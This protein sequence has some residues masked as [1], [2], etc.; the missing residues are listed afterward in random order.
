MVTAARPSRV[1]GND[2]RK[3]KVPPVEEFVPTLPV[4]V[5]IPY[6]EAPEALALTLAALEGQTYPSDLIEVIVVDDGSTVPL[7]LPEGVDLDVT[8]IRQDRRGFGAARARNRGA[9]AASHD[10]LVFLDCD[11][12]PEA[13][14]LAAH[15]RWHHTVSDALTLG[16][17][18]HVE[19]DGLDPG[20]VR[21]RPG[22][23]EDLFSDRPAERPEWIE[24]HMART[25][26][27]TSTADDIFRVVTSGNLGVGKGFFE[28]VGGFDESF[29]QWG[30]EDTEFG[31]RA[32]TWGGLLV[33]ERRAFCWHQGAGAAPSEEESRSLDLQQAKIAH[34]IAH[35]RFRR[36]SPGRTFA[37]PQFVVS[38]ETGDAPIDQVF[39]VIE[40]VLGDRIHDL[41]VRVEDR[42]ADASFELIR[43]HFGPDP[44]VRFGQPDQALD[45]FPTAS[46]HMRV[47]PGADLAANVVYTMRAELGGSVQ[48]TMALGDGSQVSIIRTW[49]LHR[50]RRNGR[51]VEEMGA[52][53]TVKAGS[54]VPVSTRKR[55]RDTLAVLIRW[56]RSRSR[57]TYWTLRRIRAR[58]FGLVRA[59]LRI[60]N[61]RQA[62][63]FLKWLAGAVHTRL[64]VWL[65]S[66]FRPPVEALP[67]ADYPLGAEIVAVG[68][69][70]G[71]VLGASGRVRRVLDERHTDL[72][73]AERA[74]PV[75]TGLDPDVP[76]VL[77]SEQPVQLSVPAFDPRSTNPIGWRRDADAGI[78]GLGPVE[79]L[80]PGTVADGAVQLGDRDRLL[81]VRYAVDVAAFH[82]D[83]VSRAGTLAALAATGV[84]VWL[85]DADPDLEAALG[86]GL[87]RLMRDE[88]ILHADPGERELLSV[89]MRREAHRTHSLAARACRIIS[90]APALDPPRVPD[91]TVLAVAA[92][93][94]L[95]SGL[96]DSVA[97]QTYPRLD[98]VLVL[99]G[100]GFGSDVQ[101][102]AEAFKHPVRV[103]RVGGSENLGAALN[104]AVTVSR[105]AL[106]ARMDDRNLYGPEHL[107]DLVVARQ[108][109][110]AELVAKG[111]EF[112]YLA[113]L[114]RTIHLHVGQG[115]GFANATSPLADGAMLIS[116]HDLEMAGG[117]RRIRVGVGKALAEDVA[118][119]G[120]AVY[121]THGAGLVQMI[122]G[123]AEERR[124]EDAYLLYQAGEAWDGWHPERVGLDRRALPF[125]ERRGGSPGAVPPLREAG[126]RGPQPAKVRGNDWHRVDVPSLEEFVPTLPVTVVVPY[127]EAPEALEL[128]LAALECQ[129]YPRDLF[130][131]VV[132]DDGSN[133][134]LRHPGHTDLDVRVVHQEDLGFGLARA[135]NTGARAASHGILIFLDCDMMPEAGWLAAHA[136]WHHA[137]SDGLTLGFRGHVEVDGVDPGMVRDRPGSL[138]DLFSDRP[139][140][141]PEWIEFHMKRTD[142]LTSSADDLFRVV[143]GGNLGVSRDFF[144]TVGGFDESFTQWGAEDTEFGYRAFT[145]GA[146]LVP[147]REGFC[148][149]QGVG[150]APSEAEKRSLELQRAKIAHLI[151]HYG[152]RGDVAGRSYTVPQYAVTVEAGYVPVDRL[153][154][155]VERILGDRVHDLVVTIEDRPDDESYE[156]LRRQF[157]PDPRVRFGP[158]HT[159]LD[160]FPISSFHVTIPPGSDIGENVVK[161]LRNKLGQ[162]VYGTMSLPDGSRVSIVRAWAL[163]RARRA[164]K[165]IADWGAMVTAEAAE[166]AP[167]YA[168]VL[169]S[170]PV[171]RRLRRAGSKA[172]RMLEEF[173][174]VRSFG[175]AWL[176]ARWFA[177]A[178]GWRLRGARRYRRSRTRISDTGTGSD[179]LLESGHMALF[180][181]PGAGYPLG[182]EMVTLGPQ[183]VDVFGASI[184]VGRSLD[185]R[186]VDLIVADGPEI[187]QENEVPAVYLSEVPALLSVPAFDPVRINPMGWQ[188]AHRKGVGALG[189]LGALPPGN[190]ADHTVRRRDR[191]TLRSV[192]HLEDVAAFHAD[193][194]RRAATLAALAGRGVVVHVADHDPDLE[195]RLGSELYGLMSA[196]DIPDADLDSRELL[197]IRMRRAALREHTLRARAR[198]IIG[199]GLPDPPA[200]PEVSVLAATKRPEM[201]PDLLATV[202]AQTYPRLE[203]VLVLHGD[204]FGA[205]IEGAVAGLGIAARVLRVDGRHRF[206]TVLNR[207]V[208]VSGGTLLAKIDDDDAYSDEHI[209]DLAVA[210]EYSGAELVA[211]G[212]EFVYLARSDR[213]IHRFCGKGEVASQ[214]ISVAGGTMLISRHDLDAAGGWRRVPR[215]VD[216]AL[217]EDVRRAGGQVYRTHGFGYVLVRHGSGHT[218]ENDDSYFLRHAE[219]SRP[220]WAPEFAGLA[221]DALPPGLAANRR[222]S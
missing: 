81:R 150:A 97:C 79:M 131:V 44:R 190:P 176:F 9:R 135:R 100:D 17:R 47:P 107:W 137:V 72:V 121:R 86:S 181:G 38:V 102:V 23:L 98:V 49:A 215:G 104:R 25:N 203:L 168:T 146:L 160:E 156:W 136:R 70:A 147:V 167:S 66:V 194:T 57:K 222:L 33:P 92:H 188:R 89:A 130:E 2:W 91:V 218:W 128:T 101:R 196:P 138:G 197:S 153:Y 87:Y 43:R 175:Q 94:E 40:R 59:I 51:K 132:V 182:G 31:Y 5:V 110:R 171:A 45:E 200:L 120:G 56:F 28:M 162:A 106:I 192:R 99:D 74:A 148:W 19:A 166:T 143:T 113:H 3:V 152:F 90:A 185:G 186:Q 11:M 68:E 123:S 178:V 15:A 187:V 133:I 12:M 155:V 58:V 191:D 39:A 65:P 88:R 126:D 77:L 145:R 69:H 52:T 108:Y 37:V 209:W 221:P 55:R 63:Q 117:W 96:L 116:R 161:T 184:R 71:A 177:G 4:S 205:H 73:L 13:G 16:F 198:Q 202:A 29:T 208:S 129:T 183:A 109:S 27:L 95:L 144:E 78:G 201:V 157:K 124:H 216:V 32:F 18:A 6:Y 46:F 180:G 173:R 179:R 139:S 125:A 21:N 134:P 119:I 195:S 61:P 204:G 105:G 118:A 206:G 172:G 151:A 214:I 14:W 211:K 220:G 163:H 112:L 170:R 103:M 41:V 26:E 213:T 80:P 154:Q 53:V 50:S 122:K 142:D 193:V 199:A 75:G 219:H 115:E 22:S 35:Y 82:P 20:T 48:A 76:V 158:V 141:R 24:F 1:R 111:A 85:A 30:A 174:R 140:E 189:P 93:P 164:G 159:V 36:A 42:A 8:V 83:P 7:R 165:T 67:A 210:H 60:R 127:Y 34:L 207:A 149:H 64:Q 62:R 212:S 169:R 217:I 84:V 10:V 54:L 114:D